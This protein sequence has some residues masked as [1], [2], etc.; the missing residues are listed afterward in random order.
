MRR[1]PVA[2]GKNLRQREPA[3]LTPRGAGRL[4]PRRPPCVPFSLARW[5]HAPRDNRTVN[6]SSCATPRTVDPWKCRCS[7]CMHATC[8]SKLSHA[9][10][11]QVMSHLIK[12]SVSVHHA[13]HGACISHA[14]V[15]ACR[16][17]HFPSLARP[18][19]TANVSS[20]PRQLTSPE[21]SQVVRPVMTRL[22]FKL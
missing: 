1:L 12:S 17:I 15:I 18:S 22:L 5:R 8:M 2:R 7:T 13:R 3:R 9:C 4:R 6:P 16:Y 21:Q 10:S 14:Q 19:L 20:A 11:S